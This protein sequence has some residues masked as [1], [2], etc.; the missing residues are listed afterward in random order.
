MSIILHRDAEELVAGTVVSGAVTQAPI[1]VDR[2]SSMRPFIDQVK[3]TPSGDELKKLF[4]KHKNDE[5]T[6]DRDLPAAVELLQHWL[7]L[8]RS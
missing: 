5:P 6:P 4:E 1:L 8:R 3:E 7:D 2:S